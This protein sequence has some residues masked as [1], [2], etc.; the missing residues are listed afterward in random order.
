MEDRGDF[1]V[2]DVK[3]ERNWSRYTAEWAWA[4]EVYF[5]FMKPSA[6][7]VA[8]LRRYKKPSPKFSEIMDFKTTAWMTLAAADSLPKALSALY[9]GQGDLPVVRAVAKYADCIQDGTLIEAFDELTRGWGMEQWGFYSDGMNERYVSIFKLAEM[10]RTAVGD[11]YLWNRR[12][13]PSD[14]PIRTH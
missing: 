13:P 12:V 8:S 6:V 9:T 7:A 3:K 14:D 5:A 11:G 1:R 10:E 2:H 4:E